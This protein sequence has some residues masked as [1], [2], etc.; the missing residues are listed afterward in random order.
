[1]KI[2]SRKNTIILELEGYRIC[3][4]HRHIPR[5]ITK[6]FYLFIIQKLIRFFKFTLDKI[7]KFGIN[8]SRKTK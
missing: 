6:L 8:Y 5:L 2:R 7:K 1:M 3:F 4:E